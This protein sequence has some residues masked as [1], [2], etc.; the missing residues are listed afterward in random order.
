MGGEI[1]TTPPWLWGETDQTEPT[2][3]WL[4]AGMTVDEWWDSLPDD[5]KKDN[6]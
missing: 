5:R 6:R 1:R 2:A 4:L 3:P